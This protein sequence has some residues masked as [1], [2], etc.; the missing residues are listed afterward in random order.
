MVTNS[1]LDE[2]VALLAKVINGT[3]YNNSVDSGKIVGLAME[4]VMLRQLAQVNVSLKEIA[5]CVTA[6]HNGEEHVILTG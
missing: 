1:D 5:S 6:R 4:L 2:V 3:R